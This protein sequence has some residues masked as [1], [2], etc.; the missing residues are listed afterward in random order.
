MSDTG[1]DLICLAS[2][3]TVKDLRAQLKQPCFVNAAH[4]EAATAVNIG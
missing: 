1:Y 2:L 4:Q 3:K